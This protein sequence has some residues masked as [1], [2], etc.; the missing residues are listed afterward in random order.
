MRKTLVCLAV[1]LCVLVFLAA[2]GF[3]QEKC[4]DAEGEAIVIGNDLPSAR[5]EA[6]ARAKWAAIERTVGTEVKAQSFVQNFTLVDDAIKTQTGGAVRRFKVLRQ[7]TRDDVVV[8]KINACVEPTR[9]RDAL[10]ALALNSAVAVF[11]PA[12]VPNTREN[13]DAFEETNILSETLIGRL[14]EQG[15][16]VV[17]VAPT[18]AADAAAIEKASKGGSSVLLRSLMYRFLSNLIIIGKLDYNISVKKGEDIGYGIVMPFQNVTVRLTYRMAAR[19]NKTGKMEILTAGVE[20]ARG[21]AN[22]VE[23]AAAR[24][25]ED[26]AEVLTPK[27][28]DK[29]A[30]YIQGNVKKVRIEV[31][32]VKTLD[33][34]MEVQDLLQTLV[35]VTNV[36]EKGMGQFVV[37]YPENTL[38]LANSL[39]QKEGVDVVNFSPYS[40]TLKY[41]GEPSRSD[42]RPPDEE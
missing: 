26:M 12:R 21:L 25:M 9:A 37:S 8:V 11:I 13:E 7:E 1:G 4:V 20:Q 15:Y 19:N 34:N 38:Y 10:S 36:E 30:E 2:P 40:L 14:T 6:I 32:G 41:T 28:L 18:G 29:V 5:L 33:A 27:L 22:S 31:Q 23:D 35:W 39:N 42:R 16:S 3:G 17:D 24:A